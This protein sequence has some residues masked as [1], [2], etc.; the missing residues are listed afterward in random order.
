MC[1][2]VPKI[3]TFGIDDEGIIYALVSC[4]EDGIRLPY[5]KKIIKYDMNGCILEEFEI[6]D[7][8]LNIEDSILEK[9]IIFGDKIY[10]AYNGGIQIINKNGKT[11]NEI[12]N[13]GNIIGIEV[14]QNGILYIASYNFKEHENFLE[15]VDPQ[16]WETMWKKSQTNIR[17]IFITSD[18]KLAIADDYKIKYLKLNG[19]D[20]EEFTDMREFEIGLDIASRYL[21]KSI[22][23]IS[24]DAIYVVAVYN[25]NNGECFSVYQIEKVYGED[26]LK[27]INKKKSDKNKRS[28]IINVL[29][30]YINYDINNA[31]IL[32]QN[33]NK[34]TLINLIG[35][36]ETIKTVQDYIQEINLMVMSGFNWDVLWNTGLPDDVFINKGLFSDIRKIDRK[37]ELKNNQLYFT[38]ILGIC[39]E[40]GD[41]YY[42]PTSISIPLIGVRS[43]I[44]YIPE[45]E[46]WNYF[47]D[48]ITD[49]VGRSYMNSINACISMVYKS[50]QNRILD[51]KNNT[52]DAKAFE[53]YMNICE[54]LCKQ[55]NFNAKE[56]AFLFVG[57]IK[58]VP[59]NY[60]ISLLPESD[61]RKEYCFSVINSLAINEKSEN[62][63]EAFRFLIYLLNNCDKSFVYPAKKN[64]KQSITAK[65][66]DMTEKIM[67]K[68]NSKYK[69]IDTDIYNEILTQTLKYANNQISI[70][71]AESIISDKVWLYMNE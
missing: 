39:E 17:E 64:I 33:M 44:D 57:N 8:K 60:I 26:A 46:D 10:I 9:L 23:K 67:D 70:K 20:D 61:S 3:D 21:I 62:K 15:S 36:S 5:N 27:I 47:I 50:H 4:Y 49:N 28:K 30:P 55:E 14:D 11:M 6:E 38:N 71:D 1:I 54:K 69:Y 48:Y 34:D 51:F 59:A 41:L 43:E 12:D 52:I 16:N 66:F 65:Q 24:D 53:D 40:N 42:I 45:K 32:Y 63:D 56:C 13:I 31:A 68:L 18:N 2:S 25:N 58:D 35:Y 37:N 22:F 7:K 19:E 29:I